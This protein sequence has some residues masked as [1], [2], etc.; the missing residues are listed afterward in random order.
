MHPELESKEG[1]GKL[2]AGDT[3]QRKGQED[4]MQHTEKKQ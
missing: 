2:Y 1:T 4:D 3:G